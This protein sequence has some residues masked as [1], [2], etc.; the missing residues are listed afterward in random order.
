MNNGEPAAAHIFAVLVEDVRLFFPKPLGIHPLTF[1]GHPR[2][3]ITGSRSIRCILHFQ[4][5]LLLNGGFL[6]LQLLDLTGKLLPLVQQTTQR[7]QVCIFV[8][9]VNLIQ[10]V[11]LLG[12]TLTAV[13]C[14]RCGE[15]GYL[16]NVG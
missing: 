1:G 12:V 7:G 14:R 3:L 5:D 10:L 4:L 6:L 2:H 15:T 16:R 13:R 11:D 8:T 9:I